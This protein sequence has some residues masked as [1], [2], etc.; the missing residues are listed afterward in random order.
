VVAEKFQA[1]VALGILNSRMKDFFDLWAIA[2]TLAFDGAVLARAIQTTFDHRETPLPTE[3]PPALTADF[4]RAKQ[5]QWTAFLRRTDIALTPEP[6]P[7]I[8]TNI[9]GFVLPPVMAMARAAPFNAQ[10]AA[11][12]PWTRV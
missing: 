12:G 11:G 10:W 2:A 5:A 3:T 6:F 9:A 7:E 1:M 4:A 8:Q